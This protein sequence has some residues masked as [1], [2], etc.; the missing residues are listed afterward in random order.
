ML[1]IIIP[2]MWKFK[3]FPRYLEQII[4][5]DCIGEV[6]IIDNDVQ[7]RPKDFFSHPKIKL[8]EQ[9]ENIYVNP[10]W[11]LGAKT[12]QYSNL[13]FLSDDVIAD[14]R[15]YFEAD[16]FLNQHKDIGMLVT[17][18]GHEP[19]NQP[20]VSCGEIKI[21]YQKEM[22]NV[23]LHGA[24]SLFF[25]IKDLYTPIPEKLK[26]IHGDA[27]LYCKT[28]ELKRKVYCIYD[29]FYYSPWNVTVSSVCR[30]GKEILIEDDLKIWDE[31]LLRK[32]VFL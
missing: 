4:G 27:Y 13:C 16:S 14:G 5:Q 9:K 28:V 11:N 22:T 19:H 24:Y 23:G 32:E 21:N 12:A 7:S 15:I 6:I 26:V 17:L 25:M 30:D 1:S 31:M 18:I 2:T 20:K 10:A 29:F 3:P 8:L